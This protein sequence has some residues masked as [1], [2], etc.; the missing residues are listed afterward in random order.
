LFGDAR[1]NVVSELQ[2]L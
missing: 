1:G 2:Q